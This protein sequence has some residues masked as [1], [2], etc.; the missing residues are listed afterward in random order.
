MRFTFVTVLSLAFIVACSPVL[1]A[2]EP[3]ASPSDASSTEDGPVTIPRSH[4][5]TL[6]SRA[7]REYRIQVAVPKAGPPTAG[8]P[9]I[10][11]TDGNAVF[12]TFAEAVRAQRAASML[13]V[14]IGYPSD[15]PFDVARVYDLTPLRQGEKS[16]TDSEDNT[17]GQEEFFA[18]IQDELKPFIESRFKVNR[19]R[20][21]LF[22]HS[23]GGLFVM[24]ILYTHP[25]AFQTYAAGAPSLWWNNQAILSE[26]KAFIEK[27][28]AKVDLFLFVGERDARHMV[29]D[30]TR[31]ADRLAP[32]SAHGLRVYFQVFDEEDHVSVLPTA[33]SRTYRI[34]GSPTK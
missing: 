32:L 17:G 7:G 20:Q 13:I 22:G 28:G 5:F 2:A 1:L 14:G 15:A 9:V 16:D 31:T 34:A 8:Y 25:E 24:H 3:A 29:L 21:T 27:Q 26:E 33:I 6:R 10:Y 12:A 19:E 4:Q 11:A 23:L 30:A 18:F